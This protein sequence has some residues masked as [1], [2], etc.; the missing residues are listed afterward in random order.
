MS[1]RISNGIYKEPKLVGAESRQ[2]T[3]KFDP[4]KYG[5]TICSVCQGRGFTENDE[6]RNVCLKCGGFGLT[7]KEEDHGENSDD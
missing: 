2:F 3:R 6:S 4:E 7:K 5:M 1:N